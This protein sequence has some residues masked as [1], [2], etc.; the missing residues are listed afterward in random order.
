MIIMKFLRKIKKFLGKIRRRIFYFSY[1]FFKLFSIN[2]KLI[3]AD[4]F[5]GKKYAD[6]P[7]AI[8]DKLLELR[9][10]LKIY[11]VL[12]KGYY[13]AKLPDGVKPV[14]F[15][16]FKHYF[17][18]ATAKI[19]IDNARKPLLIKK[20]KN[21][22]YIQTWHGGFGFKRMEKDLE[23]KLPDSYIRLAKNDS[24]N[25]S[26]LL[27]N[28]KWF[29]DYCRESFY[30]DG[31]IFESGFPRNDV[32][33][34]TDKFDSIKKRVLEE[35]NISNDVKLLLY[36][37]TFRDDKNIDCYNIDYD[38]LIESLKKKTNCD[39]KILIRLHPNISDMDIFDKT[40]NNLIN[41]SKYTSL[42]DLMISSDMLIS[43][44][45][46]LV[47]EYAYLDKPIIIY[48]SDIETYAKQRGLLFSFDQLPFPYA[49][50]NDELE[51][52]ILDYS[53]TKSKNELDKFYK[54]YDLRDDGKAS[55]R[56]ANRILEEIS[57]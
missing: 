12:D 39:W 29:S 35:L 45:S 36:A 15:N 41:V 32:L 24:S 54:K 16:S 40:N 27:S 4:N 6:N 2:N 8:V 20:R 21:Q 53:N 44:Y 28:S 38:R 50:N 18:L 47:F 43:D 11:W 52:I 46:S 34:Q 17:I 31:E 30:Y 33:F 42:N 56:V 1:F 19:W 49:T 22:F 55:E 26:L 37:P 3:I 10:D 7:A 9:D 13:D 5:G 57:K 14:K 51:K 23:G 48:A 25:M